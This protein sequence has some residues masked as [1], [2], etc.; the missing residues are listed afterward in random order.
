MIVY[1]YLPDFERIQA[2]ECKRPF[3]GHTLLDKWFDNPIFILSVK[4]HKWSLT[5]TCLN[6]KTDPLQFK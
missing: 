6:S 5:I 3:I 1:N 4:S 2:D